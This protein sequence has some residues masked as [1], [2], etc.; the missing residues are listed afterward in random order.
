MKNYIEIDDMS[1]TELQKHIKDI[2]ESVDNSLYFDEDYV[3]IDSYTDLDIQEF[4]RI[5]R[6]DSEHY[7]YVAHLLDDIDSYFLNRFYEDKE[8]NKQ[9][10]AIIK[11]DDE[12]KYQR[13]QMEV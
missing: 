13:L 9:Q 5:A 8:F 3:K 12:A 10:W 2:F 11:A 6:L 1:D 4:M 7:S